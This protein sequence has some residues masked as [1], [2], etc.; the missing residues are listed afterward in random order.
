MTI[1]ARHGLTEHFLGLG[2]ARVCA[3]EAAD[4]HSGVDKHKDAPPGGLKPR[5]QRHFCSTIASRKAM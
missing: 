2:K 1:F 4:W 3:Y 5:Q